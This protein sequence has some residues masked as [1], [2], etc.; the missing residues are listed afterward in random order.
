LINN[1][2]LEDNIEK[3]IKVPELSETRIVVLKNVVD[4]NELQEEYEEI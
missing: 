2:S 4:V 3:K 1:N